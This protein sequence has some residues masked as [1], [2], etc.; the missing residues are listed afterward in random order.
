[1]GFRCWSDCISGTGEVV[2]CRRRLPPWL[3]LWGGGGV[4]GGIRGPS[5]KRGMQERRRIKEIRRN[6]KR[7]WKIT[8]LFSFWTRLHNEILGRDWAPSAVRCDLLY[9]RSQDGGRPL[10]S[11]EVSLNSGGFSV[12]AQ[13]PNSG[14]FRVRCPDRLDTRVYKG[15]RLKDA[16]AL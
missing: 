2:P 3:P 7:R 12:I 10:S 5:C 8:S 9:I 6:R 1:M 16:P 14:N 15:D 13:R 4:L 11:G